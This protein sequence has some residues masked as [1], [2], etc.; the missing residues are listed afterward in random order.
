MSVATTTSDKLADLAA[1]INDAHLACEASMN[2]GL[3]HAIEAGRRLLQAKRKCQYGTWLPWLAKEF[4]GSQ[5]TARVY[6]QITNRWREI[7]AKRQTAGV[8]Q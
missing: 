5:R 7:E 6:M 4:N 3:Q 8:V 1:K 2:E